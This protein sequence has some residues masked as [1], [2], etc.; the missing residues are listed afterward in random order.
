MTVLTRCNVTSQ[1]LTKIS[2]WDILKNTS[3]SPLFGLLFHSIPGTHLPPQ[4]PHPF[5]WLRGKG[6][7][8]WLWLCVGI[9]QSHASLW[10]FL[11]LDQ[12]LPTWTYE[13]FLQLWKMSFYYSFGNFTPAY[14]FTPSGIP[15]SRMLGTQDCIFRFFSLSCFLFGYFDLLLEEYLNLVFHYFYWILY[16]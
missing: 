5:S 1:F 15:S 2:N 6:T 12:V 13:S 4:P 14:S 16:F 7:S 3:L 9:S 8:A 11:L 10:V